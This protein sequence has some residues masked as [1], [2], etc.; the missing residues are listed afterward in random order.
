MS[1][2][3]EE[4]YGVKV[5][6]DNEDF[7]AP[8][9]SS[10][11]KLNSFKS[12]LT[13]F[14]D[15]IRNIRFNG[16]INLGELLNFAAIQTGFYRLRNE[17]EGLSDPIES[18]SKKALNIVSNTINQAVAQMKNGGMQRALNIEA[19]K[20]QIEGLKL[21]VDTFMEA[22]DYAVSGTAY[23]LDA[24]AK[25]ASQLGASGITQLEDLKKA[26]RGVS[27]VAAMANSDFESIAH[28]FTTVAG[29]GKLT[30]MQLQ[31]L[32]YRGLNVA[33][34]LGKA[35][36]KT[37][38]EIRDMVSKGKIDFRTFANAMDDAFGE[39][40]KDANKTFT[41]AM[42]NIK[43]ALSR[44]GEAFATPIIQNAVGIFNEIRLTINAFKSELQDNSVFEMFA[45]VVESTFTKVTK[46]FETFR[47]GFGKSAFMEEISFLAKDVLDTIKEIMDTLFYSGGWGQFKQIGDS[48]AAFVNKIKQLFNA[49][50]VAFDEVIGISNV[51]SSIRSTGLWIISLLNSLDNLDDRNI[52]DLMKNWFTAIKEIA[53]TMAE[54]LGITYD[55][56][57][58]IKNMFDSAIKS[59]SDFLTKLKLSDATIDRLKRT[60]SGVASI[61]VILKTVAVDIFTFIKPIITTIGKLILGLGNTALK[62]TARI[63]DFLTDWAK[64]LE[65]SKFFD[66]LFNTMEKHFKN[67]IGFIKNVGAAFSETFG[68]TS[69]TSDNSFIDK[70]FDFIIKVGDLIEL[71]ISNISGVSIDF[72]PIKE[73]IKNISN[74]G[75]SDQEISDTE[76]GLDKSKNF[77]VKILDW[78]K[79]IFSHIGKDK[80]ESEEISEID[81]N[82]ISETLKNV[83]TWIKDII[84]TLVENTDPALIAAGTTLGLALIIEAFADLLTVIFKGVMDIMV[85][86][87]GFVAE[88]DVNKIAEIFPKQLETLTKAF[89]TV[90]KEVPNMLKNVKGMVEEFKPFEGILFGANKKKSAGEVIAEILMNLVWLILAIAGALFLIA[91]IPAADLNKAV[92]ALAIMT[93]L[94]GGLVIA[95]A[96][97]SKTMSPI[98]SLVK[99]PLTAIAASF[100]V[101]AF[102]LVEIAVSIILV[103]N[104]TKGLQIG[105]IAT[106]IGAIAAIMVLVAG[107]IVGFAILQDKIAVLPSDFLFL[108][109]TVALMSFGILEIALAI[110]SLVMAIGTDKDKIA[111]AWGVVGMLSVM[112]GVISAVVVI[113]SLLMKD[114][115]A[116]TLA[117]GAGIMFALMGISSVLKG[118]AAV[119]VIFTMMDVEK[120]EKVGDVAQA[121]I[122]AFGVIAVLLA[123][124]GTVAGL[125]G[126]MGSLGLLALAAALLSFALVIVSIGSLI[127]S[128]SAVIKAFA[129]LV[130]SIKDF[131]EYVKDIDE[132]EAEQIGNNIGIIIRKIIESIP[133]TIAATIVSALESLKTIFPYID[134]FFTN[135][136]SPFIGKIFEQMSTPLSEKMLKAFENA[137]NALINHLPALLSIVSEILFGAGNILDSI[138][139]WLN[140]FWDRTV[141]WMEDRIPTWTEDIVNILLLLIKSINS[142]MEGKWDEFDEELT[143][144][145]SNTMNLLRDVITGAKTEND[146]KSLIATIIETFAEGISE[147][148][149]IIKDAFLDL[150]NQAVSGFFEGLSDGFGDTGFEFNLGGGFE[151]LRNVIGGYNTSPI[152]YGNDVGY[153]NLLGNVAEGLLGRTTS[154]VN[155]SRV[156]D[157]SYTFNAII[158]EDLDS[159]KFIKH[160]IR[161]EKLKAKAGG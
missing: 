85:V 107:M 17:I 99:S 143:S 100:A 88:K 39:H 160:N 105:Q 90:T 161:L 142:A 5:T 37:E 121:L 35:L 126:E 48:L 43:A 137:L 79:D 8:I 16:G 113:M 132:E 144:L 155:D 87:L 32:S 15:S 123:A 124:I 34:E 139:L 157:A 94:I 33:A 73:F 122:I 116:T 103:V 110:T 58:G 23:S 50:K 42:S 134:N 18:V 147:N 6:F 138:Y 97:I 81:N 68:K 28:I 86:I 38:A 76:E 95:F 102:A 14:S 89:E 133:T 83:L 2:N 146:V 70:I 25:A 128:V 4:D 22:A 44:V 61:A 47:F 59:A 56:R 92:G 136:F 114:N 131:L 154:N 13:S 153:M 130:E 11:K 78:I 127:S 120:I 49:V 119:L 45:N 148:S 96:I 117:A 106:A 82:N 1:T 19:A 9:D 150:A 158:Q 84:T 63:G 75:F 69:S 29:Q 80:K 27:G 141:I 104:A 54:V 149:D 66:A 51:I 118:I 111:A 129:S 12:T 140:E 7:N 67:L 145:V 77:V 52:T 30:S 156:N 74:F 46:I 40:A 125:A 72:S 98:G 93:A 109:G 55:S 115:I 151:S 21:D 91:L 31:S 71:A 57:K 36:N 108:A 64:G 53:N 41:G 152:S 26:L 20:F 101:I 112:V 10:E 159:D 60:F 3:I 65:K 62:V 135:T 24:A